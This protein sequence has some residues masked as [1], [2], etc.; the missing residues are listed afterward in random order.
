M[1]GSQH[2]GN[3]IT[4][5]GGLAGGL[6]LTPRD[7]AAGTAG[8]EQGSLPGQPGAFLLPPAA[9]QFAPCQRGNLSLPEQE[10]GF[11]ATNSG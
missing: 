4:G 1:G 11:L 10:H 8:L 9:V 6:E 2:R 7:E 5:D 3:L